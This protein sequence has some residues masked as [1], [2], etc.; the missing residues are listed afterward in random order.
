MKPAICVVARRMA[1]LPIQH[2]LK[3]V[4]ELIEQEKPRSIRRAELES[5]AK[6]LRTRTIAKANRATPN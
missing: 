3:H 5:L 4:T 6:E 2:Q 1:R